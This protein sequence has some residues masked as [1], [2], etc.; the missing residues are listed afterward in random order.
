MTTESTD[1]TVDTSE[2]G[3]S[4]EFEFGN[5]E[6][7]NVTDDNEEEEESRRP[8]TSKVSPKRGEAPAQVVEP[9][10]EEEEQEQD[11]GPTQEL[12]EEDDETEEET[13]PQHPVDD[14][15]GQE[16]QEQEEVEEEGAKTKPDATTSNGESKK[17]TPCQVEAE[18]CEAFFEWTN[19]WNSGNLFGYLDAY[20]DSD[21]TRYISA[22]LAEGPHAKGGVVIT[23]R[24]EI[25]K[26]F[27]EIFV[28]NKKQQEK[29]RK[30]KGVAG[31]LTL[32][33]LIVTPTSAN[34]DHAVV[35]GEH[36][37]ELAG[38]KKGIPRSGVFTIHV[39][40]IN[41]WKIISE[42]GTTVPRK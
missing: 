31:I 30:K 16:E 27:T 15:P 5:F 36:Q 17:D 6:D 33:K 24:R 26:V 2:K 22:D 7:V 41:G 4:N 12:K 40:K 37:M 20:W 29:Q 11:D 21:Q 19:A 18:V 14:V 8:P 3:S 13:A 38:D 25:D 10:A 28:K 39:Q 32:R 1:T 34:H 9:E 23:G 35:Y 42:H